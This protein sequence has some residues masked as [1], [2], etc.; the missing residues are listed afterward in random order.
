MCV[1]KAVAIPDKSSFM[2]LIDI[3]ATLLHKLKGLGTLYDP[4]SYYIKTIPIQNF[5]F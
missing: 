3:F 2:N 4:V 1:I 5:T